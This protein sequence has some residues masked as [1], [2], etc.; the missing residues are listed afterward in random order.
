MKLK[1][2]L[3]PI[4][5]ILLL[6]AYQQKERKTVAGPTI[7]VS[8]TKKQFIRLG[9]DA[10]RLW[11]WHSEIK[12]QLA[13]VAV[14]EMKSNF[15]RVA[16]D[17]AY[18]REKGLKD[19]KAYD[20]ILEMMTA[21]RKASPDILFFGSPRPVHEAYSAEEKVKVWGHRENV[22]FS[23]Y[24]RWIQEW[25]SKGT[26]KM[27]DGKIVPRWQKGK[28]DIPALVQY[29][30]DYLN[31]MQS[32]GFDIAFL[33]VTNEQTLIS[34]AT[35]KYVYDHLPSKLN[36]GVKMPALI[37]PSSWNIEGATNWLKSVDESKGEHLAFTIAATHNTGKGGTC[38]EFIA[39]ANRLK[40]EAWNTELHAWTGTVL[41]NEIRNSDIF[42]QHMRAGFTGIDTWLFYGHLKGR[43]H[44]MINTDGKT[45]VKTGKYE[46]FKQI[47][48][49]AN[50]GNYLDI[51]L[52][53]PDVETAA[54]IKDNVLSIW[55][56]NKKETKLANTTFRLKNR[57]LTGKT[58]EVTKWHKDLPK[59]GQ[60]SKIKAA[61]STSY[62]HGIDA[63]SLYFFKINL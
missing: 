4:L 60:R 49:N 62:T 6:S 46:I 7:E 27:K 8:D 5:A 63:N 43:D 54:F 52:P 2:L 12:D 55:V 22:P 34:P 37:I 24:P 15:V 56:L 42:W 23:P 40:K 26:R 1:R 20:Q 47:V 9:I 25:E 61:V 10:E 59:P 53:D 29:L 33:D 35:N 51:S 50:G 21:M 28:L 32:K 36:P 45:I 41:E 38:E 58:I 19:E 13:Q 39:E 11:H 16:I 14:G 18:E 17:C 31:F 44:A 48:N 3:P 30:A 57:M